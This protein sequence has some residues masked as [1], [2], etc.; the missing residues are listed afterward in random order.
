MILIGME[1]ENVIVG[2]EPGFVMLRLRV[3]SYSPVRLGQIEAGGASGRL[4][5]V[6]GRLVAVSAGLIAVSAGLV[7]V[8][9]VGEPES[10]LSESSGSIDGAAQPEA[11]TRNRRQRKVFMGAFIVRDVYGHEESLIDT[12]D[13]ATQDLL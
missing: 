7:A 6:S 12:S 11:E 5:A 9:C 4:V 8:S 1:D 3:Q 2:H 10:S 13:S